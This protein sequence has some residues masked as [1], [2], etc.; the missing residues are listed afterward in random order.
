MGAGKLIG[1]DP[2]LGYRRARRRLVARLRAEGVRD[3]ALLAAFDRVPRHLFVPPWL[4]ARAYADVPLPIGRGQ[5]ISSP[6]IHALSI[7]HAE[8]RPGHR[9]LEVGTGAGFQTALLA[10]LGTE[11]YSVERIAALH[12][13]ARA[14]LDRMGVEARLRLGD[15]SRGW[16]EYAPFQAIIVGA[17]AKRPPGALLEQLAEGGHL[18]IPVGTG[19]QELRRYTRLGGG[20]SAR[21]LTGVR[22]VPLIEEGR[23]GPVP[24]GVGA[25]ERGEIGE[26]SS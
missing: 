16:P 9:V 10:A 2:A 21:S 14:S 20:Y 17:A 11:V 25:R 12:E 26:R 7:E 15:G 3:A 5:T 24:A 19:R 13:S 22:F 18:I 4:R 6:T 23:R 1:H 8:V